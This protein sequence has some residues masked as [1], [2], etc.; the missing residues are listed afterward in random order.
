MEKLLVSFV[1]PVFNSDE[2]IAR[3]LLSIRNLQFPKGGYEVVIMDNGST[4]KTHQILRD[5]G[6]SFHVVPRVSVSA[7]RNRGV[8]LAKGEYVA[9]VDSDVELSPQWLQTGLAVFAD[10]RVVASGC[11]PGVPKDATW[12]QRT[13][14]LHQRGRQDQ[15]KL[16]PTSWLSSM[17]LIVR[18][19]D[20]QMVSG[21]NERLE[22]AE[23]VDLCYRLGQR[24]TILRNP[25]MEAVHWGEA[26]DLR[27]FWQKEV[28]RGLG[29]LKGVLS[30]G[31][32][33]DELPS[34]G[35]PLYVICIVLLFCV[36]IFFDLWY[37][38]T[39]LIPFFFILLL[40]PAL[41]LAVNTARLAKR[42]QAISQLCLLYFIYGL[43]RAYAAVKA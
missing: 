35:Y 40:L 19:A 8:A 34:L 43:A 38:Q 4:D 28:W 24:G 1:I 39:L 18:R 23:D 25:A 20:F 17:N 15:V 7:L 41:L 26:R 10:T 6:F 13:W 21:F 12:V 11:F 3:C 2:H 29:S 42:P 27:K 9:F 37:G 31:L 16:T 36:G 14:D 33:W 32:R 5:M 30:H 22:T